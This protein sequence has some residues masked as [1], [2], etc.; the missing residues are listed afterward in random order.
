MA[1]RCVT[2]MSTPDTFVD[3][4][5]GQRGCRG[6]PVQVVRAGADGPSLE[7]RYRLLVVE[8]CRRA[9]AWHRVL[10]SFAVA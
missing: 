5:S 4:E 8:R 10:R 6:R 9:A 1:L 2:V 3:I 7:R